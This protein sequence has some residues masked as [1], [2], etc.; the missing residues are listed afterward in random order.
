MRVADMS[1]DTLRMLFVMR[2]RRLLAGSI[3]AVQAAVFILAVSSVL[4]GEL[5]AIKVIG[6]AAGFG[7]GIVLGMVAEERLAIG[8]AMFRIYSTARGAA[9]ATALRAQGHAATEFTAQGKDGTVAV[10]NCAVARKAIPTVRAII[11]QADPHAFITVDEV[12][13]LSRGY[14]RH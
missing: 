14:F 4:T 7:V 11:E 3:G 6:Y 13:P 9:I 10:V 5:T 2:G 1:L 8:Y 12:R